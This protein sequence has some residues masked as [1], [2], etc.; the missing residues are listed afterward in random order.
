MDT[1]LRHYIR[2]KL[3]EQNV[4][5][6]GMCFP[7]AYQKA[8]KWFEDHFTPGAR[9]RAIKRHPDLNNKD[10]FKVVHGTVTDKWKSP[11]KPVVHGWVE[12]GNL[13]FDD[14]TKHTKPDGIPKDVYY[15]MYQPEIKKDFTAEEAVINCIKYGGEGPWDDELYAQLQQRDAWMNE[16]VLNE[17]LL[18]FLKGLLDKLFG[19]FGAALGEEAD[20][21]KGELDGEAGGIAQE[22][23]QAYEVPEP[24]GWEE[25]KPKE[26]N[27]DKAI[28]ALAV[29]RT[30]IA[31]GSGVF[32]SAYDG[33]AESTALT[34][35]APASEEE[36][37]EWE[38]GEDAQRLEAVYKGIG[39]VKGTLLWLGV[40]LSSGQTVADGI[41]ES[42]KL[43]EI[44]GK[45]LPAAKE[46]FETD[47]AP[48]LESAM[49]A[50]MALGGEGEGRADFGTS[51]DLI[52]SIAGNM[53]E[54]ATMG[55]EHVARLEEQA[56]E[57]AKKAEESDVGKASEGMPESFRRDYQNIRRK[58][59]M[60]ITKR[61]L[62]NIIR[63]QLVVL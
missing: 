7:F 25:L 59:S 34:S 42:A 5:A 51:I 15:D 31:G 58:Q 40:H 4:Q 19:I 26:N 49:P 18:D 32:E 44:L 28:W 50:V 60:I 46:W 38:S 33:I 56:D 11:P 45:Q 3:L 37:N 20:R 54:I 36:A 30:I 62:Q 63:E 13:V 55:A 21:V 29:E 16:H 41:D 6:S 35:I 27:T 10:K 47:L 1:I 2:E 24:K 61:Q 53:S 9:G 22:I 39:A 23:G 43:S 12:M 14:Q 17:G 48:G 57:A 8:E 52:K